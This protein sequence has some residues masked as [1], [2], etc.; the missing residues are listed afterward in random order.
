VP[1]SQ[2]DAV[3]AMMCCVAADRSCGLVATKVTVRPSGNP[4]PA[5]A[6]LTP[7]FVLVS[8][9][10]AFAASQVTLPAPWA[11]LTAAIVGVA[12]SR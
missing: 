12:P 1:A 6:K 7:L 2:L 11:R 3:P 10:E 4:P 8:K 5:A 9:P